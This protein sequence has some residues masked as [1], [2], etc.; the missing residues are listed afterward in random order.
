LHAQDVYDVYYT[1]DKKLSKAGA[2]LEGVFNGMKDGR[3][4][5]RITEGGWEI[6]DYPFEDCDLALYLPDHERDPKGGH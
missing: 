2:T 5:K 6:E 3:D 4:W 1:F